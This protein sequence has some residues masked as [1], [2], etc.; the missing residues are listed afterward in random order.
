[1]TALSRYCSPVL[2]FVAVLFLFATST[3][4]DELHYDFRPVWTA[5]SVESDPGDLLFRIRVDCKWPRFMLKRGT[6]LSSNSPHHQMMPISTIEVR[7]PNEARGRFHQ[8]RSA[9]IEVG[10]QWPVLVNGDDMFFFG[11]DARRFEDRL[12][13]IDNEGEFK[14][15]L[16]VRLF[17]INNK[18]KFSQAELVRSL[19][20]NVRL[21]EGRITEVSAEYTERGQTP[22]DLG[23]S[24]HFRYPIGNLFR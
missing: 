4:A 16:L 17:K 21:S 1:M 7:L 20:F 8:V 19:P 3:L 9:F 13:E 18:Q 24:P 10:S 5:A 11:F 14:V 12:R 6:A 23:T 2:P 22:G 15:K